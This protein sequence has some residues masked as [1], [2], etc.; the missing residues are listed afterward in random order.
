MLQKHNYKHQVQSQNYSS[1]F[2]YMEIPSEMK[3]K[4]YPRLLSSRT[5]NV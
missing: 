1:C 3:D 4:I 2:L 5:K